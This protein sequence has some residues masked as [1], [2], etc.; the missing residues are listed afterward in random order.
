[1]TRYARCFAGLAARG[2]GAFVPFAMLGDP[3]PGESLAVAAALVEGGADALELGIPFSDPVAD[4]PV[5][6]AAAER[7]LGA[8]TT[9]A[10]CLAL[11]AEVRRRHPAVPI[12]LLTYAN[13]ALQAGLPR[14]YRA[15]AEAGADSVLL[16]DL[17]AVEAGPFARAAREAGVEP[18]LTVPPEADGA[19][20]RR[21]AEL[22]GGYTYLLG[23]PGVTG[24]APAGAPAAALLKAL[25][26]AGTPPVLVGFGISRPG[27]VR[28]AVRAGAAGA[29]SGTAVVRIAAEHAHDPAGRRA[30]LARFVSEMK[31]G[32]RGAVARD[33]LL[34]WNSR[35]GDPGHGGT[36]RTGRA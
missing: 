4:G 24:A 33:A 36:G 2:E 25:R 20:I 9:P 7:A 30:A 28:A 15:V 17:P 10:T 26:G 34:G 29:I 19:T 16:A 32:G 21:V 27:Q 12:G 22:A 6:Q 35:V 18:V 5:I 1:M 3:D 14:F 8:G 31:S 13:L 23:R 11:V